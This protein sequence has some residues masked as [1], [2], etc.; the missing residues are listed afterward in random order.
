VNKLRWPILTSV[1]RRTMHIPGT[2]NPRVGPARGLT[3]SR[4]SGWLSGYLLAAMLGCL[5]WVGW[6]ADL[7]EGP[8]RGGFSVAEADPETG[9]RLFLLRGQSATPLSANQWEILGA[10]LE[11][12][13]EDGTTNL[14]FTPAR[15]IYQQKEK[16]VTSSEELRVV[17]G[18]GLM[19]IEGT[20]FG[21]DLTSRRLVVSN[22]VHAV[23]RKEVVHQQSPAGSAERVGPGTEDAAELIQIRSNRLE[24][25]G[26]QALFLGQV[27]VEDAQGW[28]TSRRLLVD[29]EL[30]TRRAERIVAEE[31]VS[32][33]SNKLRAQAG[34]VIYNPV[35][36]RLEMA[37]NPQWQFE[38]RSGRADS[39][40][41]ERIEQSIEAQGGV[42]MEIQAAALMPGGAWPSPLNLSTPP[43]QQENRLVRVRS[44]RFSF[45]SDPNQANGHVAT[46][47][48][49]VQVIEQAMQLDCGQ[50]II[51]TMEP[52]QQARR[53]VAS[54]NVVLERAD[55]RVT[56]AQAI[57]DVLAGRMSLEGGATWRTEQR[58]GRS[59][60]L[61]LDLALGQYRAYGDV[62]MRLAAEGFGSALGWVETEPAD[63][64]ELEL[65]QAGLE[66][67]PPRWLEI[68]SD[69]FEYR[70]EAGE[71]ETAVYEGNVQAREGEQFVLTCSLLTARLDAETRLIN[72]LMAAG[73]VE[74]RMVEPDGYRLA[75]G[76]RAMYAAESGTV[77]LTGLEGVEFFIVT[78]EG[79][80]RAV[81]RRAVLDVKTEMLELD[82]RPVI[83]TPEGELT[84]DVVRL[85]R[86]HGIL[87]A[88]GSWR[89]RLPLGTYR[90]PELPAP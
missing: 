34:Q 43:E 32:L 76:D 88:A 83:T 29:L 33:Q 54:E 58:E 17:T 72:D 69:R 20:G 81:G 23:L 49:G 41:F 30:A 74:L 60:T 35:N 85:D 38:G 52:G 21:F 68:E 4:W 87:S 18:D 78:G 80:S 27:R 67:K 37:G 55:A 2:D 45:K 26:E 89:I 13:G 63:G 28:M 11:L 50:L 82:G 14:V 24:F 71:F 15:C 39:I 44:E 66:P 79:V 42:E 59:D 48:G 22:A 75:Q 84:G 46:F 53:A 62:F 8:I 31:E 51:E 12:Y 61:E 57:Y 65:E 7:L 9:Q 73:Q 16:Y 19:A 6:G 25:E 40:V 5:G 64:M 86:R 56:C 36:E 3:C 77:V 47:Q 10:R 70:T 90:I 1:L